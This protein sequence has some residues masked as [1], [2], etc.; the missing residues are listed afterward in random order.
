MNIKYRNAAVFIK[1]VP[2][3]ITTVR[4]S[5][6]K[7]CLFKV[8]IEKNETCTFKKT[9]VCCVVNKTQMVKKIFIESSFLKSI[10]V[11]FNHVSTISVFEK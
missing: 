7:Q 10:R 3:S 6:M 1:F 5:M 9:N 11:V 4:S 2:H 8:L